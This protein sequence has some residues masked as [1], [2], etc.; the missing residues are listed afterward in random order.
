MLTGQHVETGLGHMD[1]M[2][3]PP[4]SICRYLGVSNRVVVMQN[5]GPWKLFNIG[6][7]VRVE[8]PYRFYHTQ[9][10]EKI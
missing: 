4:L 3:D 2:Q 8:I 5:F 6:L 1:G 9:T 10:V 7:P